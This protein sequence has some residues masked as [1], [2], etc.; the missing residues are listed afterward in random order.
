MRAFCSAPDWSETQKAPAA[1]LSPFPSGGHLSGLIPHTLLC[2]VV[3]EKPSCIP[4]CTTG[5]Q[6]T[7]GVPRTQVQGHHQAAQLSAGVHPGG[8]VQGAG[9]G[10]A[11]GC[12]PHQVVAGSHQALVELAEQ[13]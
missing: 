8:L 6:A 3:P 9:S 7:G 13:V 5:Y 2:K 4:R 1:L 10:P 11:P 12:L